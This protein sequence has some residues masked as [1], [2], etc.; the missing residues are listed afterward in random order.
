MVEQEVSSTRGSPGATISGDLFAK[1]YDYHRTDAAEAAGLFPFFVPISSDIGTTALVEGRRVLMFGSN[2]YLG[3]TQD[4]RVRQRSLEAVEQFGSGC[5]GSRLLN[6]TLDLHREMEQRLASFLDRPAAVVFTTGY[7]ANLGAVSALVGRHDYLIVDA[8]AHASIRDGA[9]L[10]YGTTL[11]FRHNDVHDLRRCLESVPEGRGILIVVD[12]IYSM[13]GDLAN[14]PDIVELKTRYGARLLVDEAH[15][16][17][18]A[19]A[20]GRGSAEHFGVEDQVD[21]VTGTFSKSMASVGGFLAGDATVIRFVQHMARPFLFSAS[22]PPSAVAAALASLDIIET[23]PERRARLWANAEHLRGGL[24]RLGFNTGESQTPIIPIVIGGELTMV[25]FW[26]G[27]FEGGLYTNAVTSPAVPP[28]HAL[29]RMS[30][31]AAH[32]PQQID[33]ALSVVERVGRAHGLL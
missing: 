1:C 4:P 30:C 22:S 8:A 6:G 21:L 32:T 3:L 17:G 15:A 12:G 10:S 11:K 7:Q 13:E 25:H 5:T 9:R 23:E 14:L 33:E 26:Y 27:L 28:D 18:V 24:R 31:T 19:G 20:N 29:I 16:V 2:N